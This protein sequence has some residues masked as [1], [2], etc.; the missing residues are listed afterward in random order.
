MNTIA[1]V[2]LDKSVTRLSGACQDSVLVTVG[3]SFGTGDVVYIYK[4]KT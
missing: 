1:A 2:I 3:A 4:S